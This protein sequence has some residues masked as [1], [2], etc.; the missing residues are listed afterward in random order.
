MV[1]WILAEGSIHG[2]EFGVSIHQ[3]EVSAVM[4]LAKKIG[5]SCKVYPHKDSKGVFIRFSS[6]PHEQKAWIKNLYLGP[7]RK[8]ITQDIH[9][10]PQSLRL[11]VLRGAWLGDGTARVNKKGSWEGNITTISPELAAGY[12]Q[13]IQGLGVNC[14]VTK[15]T[16]KGPWNSRTKSVV[17]RV[18]FKWGFLNLISEAVRNRYGL[19]VNEFKAR[20]SGSALNHNPNRSKVVAVTPLG[21]GTVIAVKVKNDPTIC[22]PGAVTHNCD[23][24]VQRDNVRNQEQ[25]DRVYD[26]IQSLFSLLDPGGVLIV[27][28]TR[29]HPDDAYGRIIEK[30]RTREESGLPPLFR[31]YIRSC[32]DGPEGLLFPTEYGHEQLEDIRERIGERSFAAN[33][34]NKPVAD[35][36]K[37]FKPEFLAEEDFQYYTTRTGGVVKLKDSQYPVNVTMTWDTAGTKHSSKS[38]YHGMTVVGTDIDDRWWFLAA[39]H[40]KGTVSQIITKVVGLV[41]IYNPEKLIIEAIGSFQL[42]VDALQAELDRYKIN[43]MIV[44]S[45]HGGISKEDR[46]AMLEPRWVNRR[47]IVKP[48]QLAFKAEL[49]NFSMTNSMA[50]D[51]IID[52]A[53]MH[54]GHTS[55]AG[56]YERVIASNPVDR[57]AEARRKRLGQGRNVVT[58]F[59]NRRR[60]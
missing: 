49:D 40:Y 39:D 18:Y 29:W 48:E 27:I 50:H 37:V 17:Y 32:Y 51:D 23:D 28:G 20:G 35:A 55:Q 44:E 11:A 42:W 19:E 58:N 34:L 54:I 30:D 47:M 4:L 6:V 3:N 7:F 38:D 22:V 12:A 8:A 36:D 59:L 5:W 1:G 53:C 9:E 56:E 43:V 60:W 31:K 10:L 57:E 41:S 26:Y 2:Y 45:R 21:A 15:Q 13:L 14:S 16:N 24:V 25:R 46:I 33:Y 52:S